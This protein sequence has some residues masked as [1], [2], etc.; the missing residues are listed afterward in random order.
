MIKNIFERSGIEVLPI[1]MGCWTIGGV[2]DYLWTSAGSGVIN[3]DESVHAIPKA[4]DQ[5]RTFFDTTSN[6]GCGHSEQVLGRAVNKRRD[7]VV[8]ATQFGDNVNVANK[9]V[10]IYGG[11]CGGFPLITRWP[12]EINRMNW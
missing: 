10:F 11:M 9:E 6:Y 12:C 7:S 1:G 2:W 8:I 4:V 5:D 3:D